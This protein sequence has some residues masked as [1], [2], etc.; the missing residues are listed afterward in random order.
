MPV[1]A[2]SRRPN[3]CLCSASASSVRPKGLPHVGIDGL[4]DREARAK[5]E[6]HAGRFGAWTRQQTHSIADERVIGSGLVR[7][8]RRDGVS[9]AACHVPDRMPMSRG[10]PRLANVT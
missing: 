10:S 2:H 5:A 1:R 8:F 4:G 9:R 3:N 7:S 6:G